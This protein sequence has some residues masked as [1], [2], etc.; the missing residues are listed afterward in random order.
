MR[1]VTLKFIFGILPAIIFLLSSC[2]SAYE[3]T[4]IESTMVAIDSTWDAKPDA[5]A[6]ALLAPYKAQV[7]SMMYR[8]VGTAEITMGKG[9]PESLLSNLVADVL[10][11]AATQVLGKPADMGLVNMGG[12]RNILTEG[13]ITCGNIFEILPFDN[14]LCILTLKGV[15]LKELFADIAVRRGEGVSGVQLLITK[16]GKLLRGT[17]GGLQ[18]EDDKLYTVATID[19][20]ADGNGGMTALPQAEKRE[21]PAGATLRD[22]FM[23]Y[24]EQQ[25]AAGKKITSRMEGRITIA[26]E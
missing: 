17:V 1:R 6:I 18:V 9:A 19:Y 3:V 15:Y 11:S 4:K 14:S 7:D 10:R 8:V 13:T 24:V 2:H 22:L 21:C 26:D 23:S 5:E 25:T 12:L 20:M 16:D